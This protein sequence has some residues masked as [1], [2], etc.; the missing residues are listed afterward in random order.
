MPTQ[1]T[2]TPPTGSH[3]RLVAIPGAGRND[4]DGE[5]RFTRWFPWI[6][7]A[8]LLLALPVAIM[9]NQQVGADRD[10][11]DETVIDLN[12][13]ANQAK[14]LADQ[15]K[16]ECD[17]GNL[18][19]PIC[20]TASV[21]QADPVPGPR[22]QPGPAGQPGPTGPA[23][24]AI[25]GPVGSPG[26]RGEPGESVTGPPGPPGPAGPTGQDGSEGSD[27]VGEP[28]PAGPAGEP[29]PAGPAGQDGTDGQDGS[30]AT[31]MTISGADGSVQ[32]CTRSGGTDTSPIYD[33]TYTTPPP[34]G[35]LI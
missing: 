32:S 20:Q 28:G 16:A 6:I 18:A 10:R 5:G 35:G 21:V 30:P 4:D 34:D 15:I 24:A 1:T 33:C 3:R 27:G 25:V 26:P 9:L 31:S 7:V 2:K 23:G 22:G 29:G 19:G 12:N 11:A 14:G 8:L 17:V 13:T